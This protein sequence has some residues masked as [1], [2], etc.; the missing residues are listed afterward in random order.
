MYFFYFDESG[1]ATTNPKSL[2]ARPWF[3]LAA[4][5]FRDDRWLELNS[6]IVELKRSYFPELDP[7][8]FEIKSTYIRAWGTQREVWPWTREMIAKGDLDS[9]VEKFY[10]LYPRFEVIL[11]FVAIDK[12]AHQAKYTQ[13][14]MKPRHVYEYAFT[15]ILERIDYFL[16]SMNNEVGLCFLDEFKGVQRM[17]ISRYI[18]YRQRG[19]WVKGA[20][21]RV[22]EPP[23][24]L[25][26]KY[27]QMIALADIAVYN[28]FHAYMY[29]KPNYPFLQRIWPNI[30]RHPKTGSVWGAGIKTLPIQK[31]PGE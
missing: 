17:V 4:A 28:V 19:T 25:N 24:F 13:A 29:S 5:G 10:E 1:D 7:W 11:F 2:A 18:W 22:V 27:S 23:S 16:G 6:T 15:N 3:V 8:D 20:I 26:S 14:G 9:F 21:E 30:Y 31:E 12:P